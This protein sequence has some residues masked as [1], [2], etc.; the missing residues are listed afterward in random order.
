MTKIWAHRG[1]CADAPENTL[2]A[3]QL[4]FDQ[5]ADGVELDVQRTRDGVLVVCHD[6]TIDRTSNGSGAISELTF[7]Q[8]RRLDFSNGRN[9]YAR[10]PIPT[11]AEVLDLVRGTDKV[12]DIELKNSVVRYPGMEE[13]VDALVAGF[14]LTDQVWYSSFNHLSLLHLAELG[15]PVA[16]GVLYVE[17]LVR[18]WEYAAGFGVDALHPLATTVDAGLVEAAHAA[19]I[20]VHP[21]TV[22]DPRAIVALAAAGVDA[23]ITNVPRVAREAV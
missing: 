19:G 22:D 14:G 3:F 23:I 4:A 12:V 18:P 9:G 6:E 2:P 15:S 17:Q 16:R 7:D 13:Q 20:R 1:A 10:V 11:L 5:G 8:L 21:W